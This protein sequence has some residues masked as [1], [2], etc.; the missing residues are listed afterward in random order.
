MFTLSY[1]TGVGGDASAGG[2]GLVGPTGGG[3]RRRGH[4][5]PP[6]QYRIGSGSTNGAVTK[7]VTGAVPSG[8]RGSTR[9]WGRGKAVPF[10]LGE[11]I[12]PVP[13]RLVAR[14]WRGEFVDMADLLWDNLEV[15]RR[16]IGGQGTTPTRVTPRR[17]AVRFL[18][19]CR[20]LNASVYI[21]V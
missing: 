5:G 11:G 2:A 18:M 3:R 6:I 21:Q 12:P 4:G 16:R 19:C 9:K 8:K 15:E 14:I 1:R 7:H 20:G 13:A 10:V 17:Y